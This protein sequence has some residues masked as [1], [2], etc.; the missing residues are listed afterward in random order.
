MPGMAGD[1]LCFIIR[2]DPDLRFVSI[3]IVTRPREADIARCKNVELLEQS[4]DLQKR[5]VSM[6]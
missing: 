5:P 6:E 1:E 2:K 4:K 3:L